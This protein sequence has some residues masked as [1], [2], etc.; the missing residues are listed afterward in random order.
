M[1]DKKHYVLIVE[2]DPVNIEILK[3]LLESNY[4][5][6]IAETAQKA[7]QFFDDHDRLPDIVLLDVVLPDADGVGLCLNLK[8]REALQHIPIIIVTTLENQE[9]KIRALEAGANDYLNKPIDKDE[10]LLK[11]KN[12]LLIREQFLRIQEQNKEINRYIEVIVH[13]LKTPLSIILGYSDLIQMESRE[14]LVLDYIDQLKISCRRMLH[15]IDEML[16]VNCIEASDFNLQIGRFDVIQRLRELLP[17]WKVL[18]GTK[19]IQVNLQLPDTLPLA[20]GDRDKFKD[21]MENLVENAVKY[22]HAGTGIQVAAEKKGE[23]I[24]IRVKDR[25]LG[26]TE[27][28]K[29]KVFTKFQKLSAKPTA[30]ETSTGLGLS[31][32]KRMV[33]LMGGEVGVSS[34]GKNKGAEFWFSLQT[35]EARRKTS[36]PV[37]QNKKSNQN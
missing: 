20:I 35:Q 12:H 9:D 36:S 29:Q 6:L 22:S 10:L 15:S 16:N 32:V 34:Q 2:D 14:Q 28:D 5:L 24:T 7:L 31:I 26:L 3:E 1:K 21:V 17:D 37:T 4:L 30:G 11:I 25:G 23:H 8:S 27:E 13:D 18:G 19:R 33:E